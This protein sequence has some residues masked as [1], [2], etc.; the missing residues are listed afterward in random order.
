MRK[1]KPNDVVDDFRSQASD[2][3]Q[4]FERLSTTLRNT[5][6]ELADRST[7][8]EQMFIGLATAFEGFLTV[9]DFGEGDVGIH[10]EK[11]RPGGFGASFHGNGVG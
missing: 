4:Y 2:F 7:L 5:A 9:T 10:R 1:I 3:L 11:R 8:A 6:H